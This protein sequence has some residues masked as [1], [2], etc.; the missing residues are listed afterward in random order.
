M[1]Y[2]IGMIILHKAKSVCIMY[3]RSHPLNRSSMHIIYCSLLLP[4][5][6]YCVENMG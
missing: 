6:T 4:Y 3:K 2:L 1:T 5:L